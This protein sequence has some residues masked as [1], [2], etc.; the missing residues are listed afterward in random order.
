MF[1]TKV[2]RHGLAG[3]ALFSMIGPI[4]SAQLLP[5]AGYNA[6]VGH[7]SKK[8]VCES[9]PEPFAGTLDFPSKYEGSGKARDQLNE[10]SNLRY[11]TLTE[12]ITKLEK[13][14]PKMVDVYMDSGQP[15]ALDCALRWYTTW[16]DARG[17]LG[18]AANHTGKSV[19]KWTLAALSGAYLRL[20]FSSSH[21]LQAHADEQARIEAWLGQI[22][23]K[24]MAEWNP[25]ASDKDINNHMYWAGWAAMATAVALNRQDM[26]DWS[27]KI[28]DRFAGQ[29]DGEGFLPNELRR[30]TRALNYHIF[31]IAPLAMMAAFGSANGVDL[32]AEGNGALKRLAEKTIQGV[33][34]PSLFE[35]K[36]GKRQT[37]EGLDEL[38]SKLAWLEPYCATVECVG[39]VAGRLAQ[40]PFKN[41]RLGGNM[42]SAFHGRPS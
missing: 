7:A 36:T 1:R 18:P 24:V 13:G 14:I 11:K 26:F 10:D 38:S 30:E 34:D 8:F 42:T 21:P 40:R 33:D 16:A 29:V 35:R 4:W 17:L 3:V 32:A 28:Y 2:F 15:A 5:P 27:V 31:G 6:P 39:P 9:P 23:D 19:R 41:S 12:P 22:G 20:K 37:V 25:G